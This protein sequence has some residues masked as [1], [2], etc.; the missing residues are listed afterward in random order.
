M[1][2]LFRALAALV[3]AVG[4][5]GAALAQN[6]SEPFTP[7]QREALRQ[8]MREYILQNPEVLIEALESLEERRRVEGEQRARQMLVE[9]REEIFN[10]PANPVLGNPNGNVTLVEFFDYRCPYCKQMHAPIAQLA[11]EDRQIRFVHIQLP[12]LGPESVVAARAALASRVQNRY[13]QFHDALM[14]ARGNLDEAAIIRIAQSA[15]L[16]IARLRAD[17]NNPAIM[18]ALDANRRLAEDLGVTGTPAFVV[19]DRLVPGAVDPAT[20]RGMIQEARAAAP[21]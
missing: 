16:D 13:P 1:I 17:M 12:I 20:L 21:R 6:A 2:R 9:R 14:A 18:A 3:V 10:N 5:A 4:F 8:M 15:G 19:G 7:A 11:S